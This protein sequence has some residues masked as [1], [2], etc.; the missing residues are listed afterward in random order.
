MR[1]ESLLVGRGEEA[2][3]EGDEVELEKKTGWQDGAKELS[4]A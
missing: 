2:R 3:S 4:E 1:K